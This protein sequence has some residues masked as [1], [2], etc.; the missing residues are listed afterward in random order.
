MIPDEQMTKIRMFIL[1]LSESYVNLRYTN[2]TQFSEKSNFS[3]LEIL[4]QILF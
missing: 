4:R 2:Y 1:I 3:Y